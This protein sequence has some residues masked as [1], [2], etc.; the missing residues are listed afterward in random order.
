VGGGVLDVIDFEGQD[1]EEDDEDDDEEEEPREREVGGAEGDASGVG[2]ESIEEDHP[3]RNKKNASGLGASAG[4]GARA[5]GSKQ[6]QKQR[7]L[8]RPVDV[9]YVYDEATGVLTVTNN[10]LADAKV[11]GLNTYYTL[12]SSAC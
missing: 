10:P 2:W 7:G 8:T 5:R 3:L 1:E 11:R 9:Q 6:K 4:G 12:A